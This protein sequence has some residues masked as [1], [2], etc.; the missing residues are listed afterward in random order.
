MRRLILLTLCLGPLLATAQQD[1][2]VLVGEA[3]LKV[4]LWSVYDSRL[5]SSDGSYQESQRP[6]RLDI[7]YLRNIAASALVERTGA[8]WQQ[9][10]IPAQQQQPWLQALSGLWPDVRANDTLALHVDEQNRSTFYLNGET[11]GSIEDADFSRAFLDIWL[12]PNTTRPELRL[13]LLGLQ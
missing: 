11:L 2:L 4:L 3:R 6:V 10:G 7:T 8:E 1:D 13:S 9:L 12:S 5:Y